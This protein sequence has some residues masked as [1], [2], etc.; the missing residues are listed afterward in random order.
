MAAEQSWISLDDAAK[1]LGTT[2]LNVLMH[3]KRG[4]LVGR[5]E[6]GGWVVEEDSL[7]KCCRSG[8]KAHL[9][10]GGCAGCSGG[11]S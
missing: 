9:A 7:E 8:E 11:C 10:S 4:Q 1:K 6:A 5:E 2:G 3:I